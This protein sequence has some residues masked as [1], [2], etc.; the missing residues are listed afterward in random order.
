[1]ITN[2]SKS[3]QN[4]LYSKIRTVR[5]KLKE[6]AVAG[7]KHGNDDALF[8]VYVKLLEQWQKTYPNQKIRTMI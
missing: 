1:M 6:N 4:Q 5:F 2:L 8:N 7:P 3:D